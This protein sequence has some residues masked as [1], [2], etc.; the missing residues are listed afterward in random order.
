M[1]T[2]AKTDVLRRA[3][4]AFNARELDTWVACY[5]D[6][7]TFHLDSGKKQLSHAEHQEAGRSWFQVFPD[8]TATIESSFAAGD[9]AFVRWTY[10]G[11]HLGRTASGVEP[12]GRRVDVGELLAECRFEDGLIAEVWESGRFVTKAE[13]ESLADPTEQP[14][15]G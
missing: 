12:T 6:P 15:P 5:T 2:D 9:R 10:V 13:L 7:C 1:T 8:M 4:R 14:D 3:T 11:T